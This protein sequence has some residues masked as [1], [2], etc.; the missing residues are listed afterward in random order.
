MGVEKNGENRKIERK[1]SGGSRFLNSI[2]GH[3]VI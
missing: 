3:Q 2:E 1:V